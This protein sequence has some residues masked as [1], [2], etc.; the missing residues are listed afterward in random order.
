M[1]VEQQ[2]AILSRQVL[3]GQVAANKQLW[4]QIPHSLTQAGKPRK[5]GL[6]VTCCC[7]PAIGE[8]TKEDNPEAYLS[9][10]ECTA[11]TAGWPE[12]QWAAVLILPSRLLIRC[13][14]PTLIITAK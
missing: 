14:W 3:A 10:F 9:A 6:C 7:T 12:A 8:G 2:E 13:P 11:T 1:L 5:R 4:E